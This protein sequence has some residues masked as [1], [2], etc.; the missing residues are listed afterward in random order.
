MTVVLELSKIISKSTKFT[1]STPLSCQISIKRHYLKRGVFCRWRKKWTLLSCSNIRNSCFTKITVL[2]V[3]K[4]EFCSMTGYIWAICNWSGQGSKRRAGT[5]FSYWHNPPVPQ[6]VW[7]PVSFFLPTLKVALQPYLKR[8]WNCTRSTNFY[9][10]TQCKT[11][12]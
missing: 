10:E 12:T 3:H 5:C 11:A 8:Q 7:I 6:E 4:T 9:W 2:T 1:S